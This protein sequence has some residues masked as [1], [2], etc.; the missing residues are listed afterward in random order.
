MRIP[1][2]LIWGGIDDPSLLAPFDRFWHAHGGPPP[3]PD[4]DLVSGAV[5]DYPASPGVQAIAAL[6]RWALAR[7][8]GGDG[9]GHGRR[10]GD[11][12]GHGRRGGGDRGGAEPPVFP[13]LDRTMDYFAASLLLLAKVAYSESFES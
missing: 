8:A 6:T 10:G 5:A 7:A 13:A 3:P 1:L 4:V 11:S 9:R 2:Y 12:R